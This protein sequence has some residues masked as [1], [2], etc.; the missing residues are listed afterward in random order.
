MSTS[1]MKG[2]EEEERAVKVICVC[3]GVSGGLE[4][5]HLPARE[6]RLQRKHMQ[7]P[8][9]HVSKKKKVKANL[10]LSNFFFF[11]FFV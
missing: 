6:L 7:K 2:A 4:L 8:C 3:L 5:R 1:F 9:Q 11:F 10:T